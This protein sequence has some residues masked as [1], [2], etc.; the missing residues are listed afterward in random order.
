MF[1]AVHGGVKFYR[2]SPAAARS[3]VEK[4]HARADDYYLKEGSGI[5][6]LIQASVPT[7]GDAAAAVSDQPVLT[8]IGEVDGDGYEAWVAGYDTTGAPKGRLRKDDHSLRFVEVI[9]NGPKTWSLAASVHPEIAT[10]YDA[11]QDRAARE[12]ISWLAAHSTTRIG[13]RGRQVQV[14]VERVEAAVVRHYTSRAG[15]P[16][17]HLHLQINARVYAAGKWR[18][19]HSTGTVDSIEA[20]NGIGHAAVLCDPE[21][22]RVLAEHGY[23]ID[24]DSG[25]ITHL[26][27]YAARFSH[28]AAQINRNVDEFEAE[29]RSEYP[30]QEPGPAL[31]Q[32]WDRRAWAQARPDKV[33]PTYGNE[34]LVRWHEELSE[35]GFRPPPATAAL[36][37]TPI[38][39]INRDA[40]TDLALS[41]LGSRHSAW[42]AADIRGEIE[43]IIASV[44]VVTDPGV[45]RELVEDLTARTIEA[46][47]PLVDRDDVP[48][49]IRSL[50]SAQVL[51]VENDLVDRIARR[52]DRGGN[53]APGCVLDQG[54]FAHGLNSRPPRRPRLDPDQ[55]RV[56]AALAGTQTVVV[57]EGAAGAGKT[58][59]L[60][61][62]A[63][64]LTDAGHRL[65]VTTPTL[66][67]AQVAGQE[68]DTAASSAG[69]LIHHYG[70]QWDADGHWSREPTHTPP[71]HSPPSHHTPAQPTLLEAGELLLVDEAGMLDQDTARALLTIA[72][73]TGA[74]VAF[75]GDRH[76]LPAVGRGGVLDHATRVGG[77]TR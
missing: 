48:E 71:T 33:V 46:C 74:R 77:S 30:G 40:V 51:A 72:D 25:E 49:H 63:S 54:R 27:P 17:R 7:P 76:Q 1:G 6:L 18:G 14:P 28:R 45:R 10:A 12:V 57:I 39:R 55:Q 29:W 50:T 31:R 52:A 41:R 59:T 42:T 65:V 32:A 53:P 8:D 61:E 60:A 15:D 19:L 11:A 73:E 37:P 58:T 4:D 67:A 56:V 70:F 47:Q 69:C 21:F 34:L 16:H 35:L 13:P 43:R 22:R 75:M 5:A 62:A 68:L 2:G 44:G 26:A 36:S 64:L 66:K 24:P 3:Y 20:I 9:I 23:T 38:G